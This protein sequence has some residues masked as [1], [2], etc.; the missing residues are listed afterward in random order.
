MRSKQTSGRADTPPE[1][2]APPWRVE[3]HPDGDRRRPGPGKRPA[4]QRFGWMLLALLALNW[5]ISSFLLAPA[6]RTTVSYTFFLTQVDAG[7]IAEI[8][9]T[10]EA[11]DGTFKARTSYTP[12]G[13]KKAERV[14]RF[15]TQRP[16]FAEDNLFAKL[17]STNV[18]VNAN[19]PDR[20]APVWQQVLLG[21]G[22]TILLVGLLIW[23]MR[24]GSAGSGAGIGGF[25][26]SR[27][28]L[29]QPERGA[30]TCFDDVAGIE[31]VEQEVTEIVDFLREPGKYRMLGAQIPHGVLLSGPPGT[32]KTLLARAVAGEAEVPFFSMSASEF[33]EMIVGVGASRVRDLFEQAKKVAPSIIFID[34]LD[35][36][37]RAR[38]GSQSLGGSDEREQ[39]LNQ[40]LTEMD[41]FTG[42]EGVV[43]LAATNRP[44]VL[45]A[46]LLRPGRFDRRVT[47]SPPDL[48]GRSAILRVHT[49]GVPVAPG[50]DLESLASATPGM[51]GAD[52]KNLVN[53]AALLAARRGHTVVQ[54]NDFTDALEKIM[55]GTV[56]GIMLTGE[57]KERTAFHESGHALLGMLTPG[58]DP[59]RKISIIPRG[60]ALGVT[61]QSPSADR[62]GYSA[63][64]LRGRIIGALGGRAA[65]EVVYGDMTTGAESD[66]DQ[67]STIARQMVGRWGMSDAIGPVSVLPPP[68]SESPFGLDGV[69]PATKE[70][71]DREV[72]RIVDECYTAALQL[73]REHREQ[74]NRLAGRLLEAETL[75]EADAYAAAGIDR[76]QAPGVVARGE[77]PA[78]VPAL[79]DAQPAASVTARTAITDSDAD[80]RAERI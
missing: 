39:T 7:N 28:K 59:V 63:G 71:I 31:E 43:V 61:F 69:A 5:V 10:S 50:V 74:L 66:L 4:W 14:E 18:P 13:A 72:R 23:F 65:E 55:L 27:A 15:T 20:R 2:S 57:E 1:V 42:S 26:K 6:P 32:G 19:N 80:Q 73:L 45:D 75:D 58:A 35:A 49:R 16:S 24:R 48:N 29:Y 54:N 37:G 46:A 3:G 76:E 38:G 64:Y 25:G 40:I 21:F 78:L 47:V 52:L 53:E 12:T 11:I 17:Q 34:E 41:G 36:I 77:V 79:H 22:P 51:V 56:R 33:I 68:G 67:V 62:Y 30:R 44:E 9:S 8:T 70:L 60:Q